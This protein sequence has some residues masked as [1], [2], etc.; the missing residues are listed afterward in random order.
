MS[1]SPP[2]QPPRKRYKVVVQ[3][4]EGQWVNPELDVRGKPELDKDNF[5]WEIIAQFGSGTVEGDKF[6]DTLPLLG[7]KLAEQYELVQQMAPTVDSVQAD[8]NLA[9]KTTRQPRPAG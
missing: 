8:I 1:T 4:W 5:A 7:D 6:A 3:M 2:Q 9:A